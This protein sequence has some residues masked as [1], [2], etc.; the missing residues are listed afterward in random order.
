[1]PAHPQR[2]TGGRAR[3]SV[4][5]CR[6]SSPPIQCVS[7]PPTPAAPMWPTPGSG[8]WYES[9]SAC[10]RR[11]SSIR[12]RRVSVRSVSAADCRAANMVSVGMAEDHCQCCAA[13]H[14]PP[15]GFSRPHPL[16]VVRVGR[17]IRCRRGY[18]GR[19]LARGGTSAPDCNG[20]AY[21]IDGD[22]IHARFDHVPRTIQE[23]SARERGEPDRD[24]GSLR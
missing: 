12:L 21:G 7:R 1:M 23:R 13:I 24:R 20:C 19:Q 9:T 16:R 15:S 6:H 2:A 3:S 11:A 4:A 18:V 5:W 22:M 17:R 8:T 14:P 10:S